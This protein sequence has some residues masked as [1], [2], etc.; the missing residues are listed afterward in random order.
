MKMHIVLMIGGVVD[1]EVISPTDIKAKL[2]GFHESASSYFDDGMGGKAMPVSPTMH[3]IVQL[4]AGQLVT[5]AMRSGLE[6]RINRAAEDITL[7]MGDNSG[8][9]KA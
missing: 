6:A 7:Q 1:I 4:T 3:Q 8:G 9:A 2:E 5:D